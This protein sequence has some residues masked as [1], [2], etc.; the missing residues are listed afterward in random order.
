[1]C[2][3]R[4]AKSGIKTLKKMVVFMSEKE[5]YLRGWGVVRKIPECRVYETS[6]KFLAEFKVFRRCF[7]ILANIFFESL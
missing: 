7:D 3:D 5:S 1:M 6:R 2:K 4:K